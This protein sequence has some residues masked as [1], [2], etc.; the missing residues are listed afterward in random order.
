MP[1][2]AIDQELIVDTALSL[3]KG[4]GLDAVSLSRVAEELG[5]TQ[6][7]LYHH[8]D[9]V[10]DLWRLIGLRS[11]AMLAERLRHACMGRSGYAALEAVSHAWL[12]FAT[13]QPG[14]YHA[15]DRYPCAGDPEVEAAVAE[16]VGILE[17]AL[18]SFGLGE[19]DQRSAALT[20]RNALHGHCT[21]QLR[22][23]HPLPFAATAAAEQMI[24]FLG[25]GFAAVGQAPDTHLSREA[26]R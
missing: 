21:F 18:R 24:V 1:K 7:A 20:L 17:A 13:D 11:R 15:D 12:D 6:P 19:D 3:I 4:E 23:G 14:L 2:P 8:L 22:D 10:V 26:R 25:A 9:G 16:V 5:V